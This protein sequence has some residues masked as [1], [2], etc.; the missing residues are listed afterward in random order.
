MIRLCYNLLCICDK[1]TII[2]LI[3]FHTWFVLLLGNSSS[4][5]KVYL[6][7]KRILRLITVSPFRN[8]SKR[9]FRDLN[10]PTVKFHLS[11]NL[12]EVGGKTG[13]KTNECD[14][15]LNWHGEKTR[16]SVYETITLSVLSFHP[17]K[18]SVLKRSRKVCGNHHL[19]SYFTWNSNLLQ[20]R[21]HGTSF[22]EKSTYYTCLRIYVQ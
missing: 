17:S 6:M 5:D 3:K 15:L 8:L 1:E 18:S 19:H 16:N 13:M 22:L 9:H 10:I 14:I 12:V 2:Q 20:Y 21:V 4:S 11:P 7:Q